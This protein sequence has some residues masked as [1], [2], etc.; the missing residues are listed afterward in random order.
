MNIKN[1]VQTANAGKKAR[2]SYYVR[3][4]KLPDIPAKERGALQ[5]KEAA[6]Y[7]SVSVITMRNLVRRG[8][9]KPCRIIGRPLFPLTQLN[10]VLS[11][12]KEE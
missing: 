12:E 4:D 1:T 3:R 9:L 5:I 10:R 2:Q 7:L 11:G 8:I 6:A